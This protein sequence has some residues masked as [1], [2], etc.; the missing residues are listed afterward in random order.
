MW[1]KFHF[2]NNQ[3]AIFNCLESLWWM[4]KA[5]W[6][7]TEADV[8]RDLELLFRRAYEANLAK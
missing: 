5:G 3:I 1:A 7:L 6:E 2:K 8:T 4:L